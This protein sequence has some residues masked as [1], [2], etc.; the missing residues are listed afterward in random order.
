M[1][2]EAAVANEEQLATTAETAAAGAGEEAKL[3]VFQ[4][5][6]AEWLPDWAQPAWE[7]MAAWPVVFLPVLIIVAY[8]VG[9]TISAVLTHVVEKITS[10]TPTRLDD[11]LVKALR[12]PIL[13]TTVT[14]ALLVSA[15]VMRLPETAHNLSVRLLYTFLLLVWSSAAMRVAHIMLEI[16]ARYRKQLGFLQVRTMPAFDMG[17]KV[18]V[19]GVAAFLFL[20]VW[21]INPTAWL[22]LPGVIGIVVGFAARDTLANFFSGIFIIADA[23][24]KIG[25]YIILDTG[26]RG[27]VKQVGMRST[28]I[29]TRDDIEVTIPNA[30]I[31]NAKIIN[32]SGGPWEKE[33]I[34]IPV[35]V[36]YGSDV[37]QV[38][39]LLVKIANEHEEVNE[40]L[41]PRVRLRTF[42]TSS[43]DFELLC[44]I[45]H[46][47]LRGRISH[48]LH[49]EI[50]RE[51]ATA[52]IVIPYPQQ[53][54]HV[55]SMPESS[56]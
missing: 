26:E 19:F 55:R 24:Y 25:D 34:R 4:V 30:V 9:W 45:E 44:W 53:D 40:T 28:R 50:Y 49:M 14:L 12:R 52:G 8:L 15:S 32:E 46:P 37:D 56:S 7:F 27:M 1:Q 35:G 47:E 41:K 39:E 38:C 5:N 13:P 23:P 20:L 16:V 48:E 10:R 3:Q 51:F 31:G 21:G 42:G 6:V 54:I 18:L 11:K 22:A 2:E 29:L 36:A 33:R 43:I 17:V